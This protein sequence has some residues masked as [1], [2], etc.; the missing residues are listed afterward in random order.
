MQDT[1]EWDIVVVDTEAVDMLAVAEGNPVVDSLEEV[2][3]EAGSLEALLPCP[4]SDSLL[5]G[6]LAVAR[7]D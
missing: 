6:P 1:E 5:L 2:L 3:L 4:C 7:M